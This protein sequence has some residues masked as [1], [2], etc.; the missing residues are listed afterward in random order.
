M[1]RH[2]LAHIPYI[3]L[4]AAT[5]PAGCKSSDVRSS[6]QQ[7]RREFQVNEISYVESDAFDAIFESA[8]VREDPVIVVRTDFKKP[9]WGPRLNAWIAAWNMGGAGPDRIVRGQAP[10]P[11]IVVDG[12]SIREFRLLVNSLMNRVDGLA[13]TGTNWWTEE[14]TRS[15]RVS[16]LKPYNLRFHMGDDGKIQLVFFHGRYADYYQSYMRKLTKSEAE[17]D[18][19]ARTYDCTACKGMMTVSKKPAN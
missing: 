3:V 6:D 14:R 11:S 4:L 8:L 5:L 16:L 15:R 12:D 10:I 2:R 19:W 17:F 1:F 7:P 18:G 13:R 9:E